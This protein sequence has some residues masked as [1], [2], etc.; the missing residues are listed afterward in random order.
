MKRVY[1]ETLG[2]AKNRVDTELMLGSLQAEGYQYASDPAQAEVIIVN[3]CGF[4]SAAAQES[5]D[6][7]LE[8]ADQKT[9]GRCEKLISAGCMSERYRESLLEEIPELDGLYGSSDFTQLGGWLAGLYQG[10]SPQAHLAPKPHYA[11]RE[12]APRVR[13]TPGHYAYLKVAEGCSNMCTFC[14][15][16]KLRGGFSS[17]PLAAVQAEA[18]GLVAAGVREINL[19]AQDSS[20]YGI[21]LADGTDLAGL[22]RALGEIPPPAHGEGFWV[23]LF[24]TYP[25]R[26]GERELTALAES[27]WVVPYVDMPFQHI[28][29]PVLKAMNRKI[30]E[31]EIRSKLEAL[32][33][34]LPQGALRTT[35]ITGFPTETEADFERLLAF[36]KEGWFDHVGVFT[37]SHEDNIPSARLGDPVPPAVKERRRKEL[38]AAQEQVSTAR[39]QS[40]VGSTLKVLVEGVSEESELLLQGRAAFQGPEVDG[41]VLINDGT[42]VPGTFRQVEITQA[43]PYDLV[44]RLV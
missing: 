5:V 31:G 33:G 3:T 6:R 13:S 2:C 8:L 39:N 7:I 29:D 40:R 15:I 32:R 20:S 43:L 21:D 26:F 1:L 9:Q 44:G 23:R 30:T 25:N 4:L 35:F 24:Y 19:V 22:I 37:Y 14:N 36:V 18:A 42:A 12:E 38:M 16:P 34:R 11:W 10:R 17:R 41:V 28:S 27:P